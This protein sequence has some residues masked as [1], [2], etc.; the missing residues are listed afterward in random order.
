MKNI[1]KKLRLMERIREDLDGH[2][3][4]IFSRYIKQEGILFN[5]PDDWHID[6]DHISFYGSDGCMGCYDS[7]NTS[8]PLRYFED[9]ETAFAERAK[10]IEDAKK[11]KERNQREQKKRD[12]LKELKRL[13]EKYDE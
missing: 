2:I 13:K 4:N 12:D 5:S 3:W 1:T 8:I 9:P 6:G 11:K 10:E 7:M